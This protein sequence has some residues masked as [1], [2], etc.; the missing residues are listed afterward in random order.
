MTSTLKPYL[1]QAFLLLFA[2][3]LVNACNTSQKN[4]QET[5]A[6]HYKMGANHLEVEEYKEAVLNFSKAIEA[7]SS[8]IEAYQNR[9][10]A[11]AKTGNIEAALRDLHHCLAIDSSDNY[12]YYYIGR[13][14]FEQG[15]TGEALSF[16]SSAIERD[17]TFQ[18]AFANRAAVFYSLKQYSEAIKDYSE[19]IRLDQE[20]IRGYYCRGV[21]YNAI[22]ENQKAIADFKRVLELQPN[23]SKAAQELSRTYE[24]LKLNG[25]TSADF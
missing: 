9:S 19:A 22:G 23:H 7:D 5:A 11:Y 17:A 13:I 8:F 21:S 1:A 20:Y 25:Y 15:N 6:Y 24:V 18:P 12:T 3:L 14:K 16:F 2:A 10:I 4:T